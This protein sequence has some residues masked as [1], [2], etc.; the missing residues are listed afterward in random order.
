MAT[1]YVT[2]AGND[3]TGDGTITLPYLTI[4]KAITV[5]TTGDTINI[6]VGE[7]AEDVTASRIYQG[8]S[9]FDTHING[10]AT[11]QYWNFDITFND[12][13]VSNP[14]VQFSGKTY[15]FNR[16]WWKFSATGLMNTIVEGALTLYM[17]YSIWEGNDLGFAYGGAFYNTLR[18][19]IRHSIVT[20]ISG[21]WSRVNGALASVSYLE[22]LI[23]YFIKATALGG[24]VTYPCALEQY[25]C[26]YTSGGTIT[27]PLGGAF[28]ATDITTNPLFVDFAGGDFRLQPTSPCIGKGHA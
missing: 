2:K 26:W 9:M 12:I 14:S 10:V 6:G 21:T 1:K 27:G 18:L 13:K 23:F 17:D 7:W 15:R 3:T 28:S 20:K 16:S 11:N 22:N 24:S 4:A 5:T 8:V 19:D 25:N